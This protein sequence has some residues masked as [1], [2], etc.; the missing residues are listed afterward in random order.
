[1]A[2][3]IGPLFSASASG[4]IMNSLVYFTWKGLRVVRQYVVPSN[5]NTSGQQSQRSKL[6]DAVDEWHGATYN[7]LDLTAWNFRA[8]RAS[9][10]MSGFNAMVKL[11]IEKAISGLTWQ[12]TSHV[13][14]SNVGSDSFDVSVDSFSTAG[15]NAVTVYYGTD[16]DYMPNTKALTYNTGTEWLGTVGGLESGVKYYFKIVANDGINDVAETGI[17]SQKTD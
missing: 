5:P 12:R 14:I 2:K 15:E 1:M 11:H 3:V 7:D 9:K 4:K 16:P 10:P 6:S 13:A 8:S 17:Y